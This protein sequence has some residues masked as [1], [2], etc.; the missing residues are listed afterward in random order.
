M[1]TVAVNFVDDLTNAIVETV[2][3]N[4]SQFLPLLGRIGGTTPLKVE[5]ARDNNGAFLKGSNGMCTVYPGDPQLPT[6][7]F[8]SSAEG[9]FQ[10]VMRFDLIETKTQ[11]KKKSLC[12]QAIM[13]VFGDGGAEYFTNFTDNGTNRLTRSGWLEVLS[14]DELPGEGRG[15]SSLVVEVVLQI[16]IWHKVPVVNSV[17]VP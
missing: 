2:K 7:V 12:Q 10:F 11:A 1:P 5:Y 6:R 9:V 3:D 13:A 4:Q 17:E 15:P 14:I 16:R 8:D